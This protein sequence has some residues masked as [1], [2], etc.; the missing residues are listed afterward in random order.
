M[1]GEGTGRAIELLVLG[2][3]LF[4]HGAPGD[5]R[6][7]SPVIDLLP[8]GAEA[9]AITLSYFGLCEWPDDGSGFS[10]ERHALDIVE[11]VEAAMEPPVTLV[12]WSF[13]CHPALLAALERP[14]L[15]AALLLYEPS[16]T[17]Y[18]ED[19]EALSAFERDSAAAFEP[20]VE[21]MAT[22]GPDAAVAGIIDSSGGPGCFDALPAERQCIYRESARM[23]T[24]LM[25]AGQ[26]PAQITRDRLNRL[27]M[28]ATVAMGADTRPIFEIP[29]RALAS[30]IPGAK[31]EI[32]PKAGHMLP[33]TE[34]ER[35]AQ[36]VADAFRLG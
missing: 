30:A 17:T 32:L 28:P 4:I 23:L 12:G 10:T 16:L 22:E 24:L 33:E 29:S 5:A 18:V 35:F 13:G 21:L 2:R 1:A 9:R 34:P 26:P 7:W 36:L 6:V 25:G 19:A 3:I 20:N 8:A 27:K 31:L 15:F 11:L 14:D